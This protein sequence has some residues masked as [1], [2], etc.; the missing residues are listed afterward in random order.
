[1]MKFIFFV[2]L[3]ISI[4]ATIVL[5]KYDN[6][7]AAYITAHIAIGSFICFILLG[8]ETDENQCGY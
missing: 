5:H 2:L 6:Y 7:G 1:M 4:I 3:I 8:G